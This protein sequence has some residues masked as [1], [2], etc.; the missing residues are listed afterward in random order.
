MLDVV[1]VTGTDDTRVAAAEYCN[2]PSVSNSRGS[3]G[4]TELVPIAYGTSDT[5]PAIWLSGAD[6]KYASPLA[7]ITRAVSADSDPGI[8]E[9]IKHS[10]LTIYILTHVIPPFSYHTQPQ[11]LHEFPHPSKSRVRSFLLRDVRVGVSASAD[12]LYKTP[13]VVCIG[14]HSSITGMYPP[15]G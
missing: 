12:P 6:S 15:L 13:H 2:M 9:L 1:L 3:N 8:G 5:T 14:S 4:V 11:S 10:K 7:P